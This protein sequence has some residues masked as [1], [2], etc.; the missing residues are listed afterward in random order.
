MVNERK[1]ARLQLKI[2][3]ETDKLKED[4]EVF[5]LE[6][7]LNQ[8]KENRRNKR[9][10]RTRS[11]FSKKL[12]QGINNWVEKSRKEKEEQRKNGGFN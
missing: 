1:K 9:S 4:T 3:R 11:D 6:E 7:K 12:S 10:K 5:E 8:I 2:E